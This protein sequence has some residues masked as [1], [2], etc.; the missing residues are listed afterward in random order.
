M[1]NQSRLLSLLL[2]HKPEVK[3]LTL[4]NYGWCDVEQLL[5]NTGMDMESLI[6]IVEINDKTRFRFKD[7]RT[8]I[9]ASQGHSIPI[10]PDFKQA[11]PPLILYHGTTIDNKKKIL[12]SGLN[13]MRRH[14]VHM[15]DNLKT[16][17]EVG[18]RY[19][20]YQNK[21]W[22]IKIDTVAMIN[23]GYKFYISDNEVWLTDEVPTKFFL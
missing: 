17:N 8:K 16:S 14:H 13:K 12:R 23:A 15:T 2:R 9:K 11:T 20:K 10:L 22:I 3:N 7:N 6:Q 19:A 5:T 21:L 18:M 4:D 1:K